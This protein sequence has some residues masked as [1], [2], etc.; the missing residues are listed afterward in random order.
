VT[1]NPEIINGLNLETGEFRF[2]ALND[3]GFVDL[4]L[5]PPERAMLR[6]YGAE[7]QPIWK[8]QQGLL[9]YRKTLLEIVAK[10]DLGKREDFDK[11]RSLLAEAKAIQWQYEM[12]ERMLGAPDL[13]EKAQAQTS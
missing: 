11:A 10:L 5:S 8:I 13:F 7:G 9:D 2:P 1:E 6:P 3:G 12:W 4:V